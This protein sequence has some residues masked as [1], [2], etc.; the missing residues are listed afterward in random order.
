MNR[1]ALGMFAQ[2]LVISFSLVTSVSFTSAVASESSKESNEIRQDDSTVQTEIALPKTETEQQENQKIRKI[3]SALAKISN[4]SKKQQS[5]II[6]RTI[7]I[8]QKTIST[9][10]VANSQLEKEAA[11][12]VELN[13]VFSIDINNQTQTGSEPTS[14]RQNSTTLAQNVADPNID[15]DNS[16]EESL[17]E[18]ENIERQLRDLEKVKI[19]SYYSSPSL[20]IYVPV[21]YGSD[22]NTGF[23]A[24]SYQDRTRLG[25]KNDA[26]IGFGAGFGNSRKSVGVVLSYTLASFGTNR[27]FGTGGFNVKVHRQ[28]KGGWAAAVGMNGFLNIGDDND[29]EHS[30][31]GV[32]TK[33]FRIRD[34]INKP[35]SRIAVTAGIGNGEFRTEEALDNDEDNFNVFGNVAVRVHPQASLIT[36]WTGRDLGVGASIAPFKH[37]PFVI[38]PAIR[39]IT[40]SDR[41]ARFILSAGFGFKF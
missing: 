16:V 19:R 41:D 11:K 5:E 17:E 28:F 37:F 12:S 31:Y 29:F 40:G 20:S 13:P 8:P 6:L 2:A 32:A 7:N 10:T 4:R 9:I 23:V 22:N 24:A 14:N 3:R 36:E 39:D 25:N 1:L 21:G 35:F 33:I 26:A 15:P 38:T 34:D 30:L 27:D 18:I